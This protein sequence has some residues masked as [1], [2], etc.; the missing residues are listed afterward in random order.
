MLLMP[1]RNTEPGGGKQLCAAQIRVASNQII[2]SKSHQMNPIHMKFL[3]PVTDRIEDK[4]RIFLSGKIKLY[5]QFQALFMK[6]LHKVFELRYRVFF[7]SRTIGSLR[8]K[9]ITGGISPIIQFSSGFIHSVGIS[10]HMLRHHQLRKFIYRE[11][12]QTRD[13]QLF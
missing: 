12:L 10:I 6:R 8:C 9:I 11:K 5:N 4:R 7:F 1:A 2:G 13:A 3:R